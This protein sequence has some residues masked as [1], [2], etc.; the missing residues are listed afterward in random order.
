MYGG[1]TQVTA[2]LLKTISIGFIPCGLVFKGL[3]DSFLLITKYSAITSGRKPL[4]TRPLPG[5]GGI[6]FEISSFKE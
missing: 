3:I 4:K 2:D 6:L 1:K 5:L